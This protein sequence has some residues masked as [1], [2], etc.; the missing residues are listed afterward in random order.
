MFTGTVGLP[1][2]SVKTIIAREDS[3]APEGYVDVTN[4]KSLINP[5]RG[6]LYHY[7]D[8]RGFRCYVSRSARICMEGS[9]F[10]ILSL[11]YILYFNLRPMY[12]DN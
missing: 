8:F 4:T 5:G 1:F 12:L 6:T 10:Q 9:S 3:S 7:S 11:I 2:K